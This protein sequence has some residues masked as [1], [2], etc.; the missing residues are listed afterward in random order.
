MELHALNQQAA[1]ILLGVTPRTLRDWEKDGE[2]TPRN[3]DGTYS[4]P[5]LVA[6]FVARQGGDGLDL[7]EQR[8]RLAKWQADKTEQEVEARAGKLLDEDE[9]VTWVANMISIVKARFLQIPDAVGQLL[10]P[11]YSQIVVR[12]NRRLIHEALAELV[13]KR[14]STRSVDVGLGGATGTNGERMGGPETQTVK[15]KQRRA[16]SVEN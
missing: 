12:E 1:A 15:R 14:P 5:A 8:A 16:R 10:D 6:W 7:N 4:G 2:G 3:A 9:V 13:I 11:K